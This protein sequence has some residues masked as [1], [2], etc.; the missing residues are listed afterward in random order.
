MG[1]LAPL[2]RRSYSVLMTDGVDAWVERIAAPDFVWDVSPMG[3]GRHEG[4]DE[5]RRFFLDWTS[6]YEDWYIEP[7]EIDELSDD[8]VVNDTTQGGRLHGSDQSVELRYG[9]LGVWEG[10]R[11]K[12]ALSYP[13]LDEARAAGLEMVS[14]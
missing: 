10:D 11:L 13:S 3:L 9:Q 14:A 12:L 8:V 2:V 7:G 4:H 5:F 1:R 6:S